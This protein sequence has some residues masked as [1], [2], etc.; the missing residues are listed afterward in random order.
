MRAFRFAPAKTPK[1]VLR[2]LYVDVGRALDAAEVKS[3]LAIR[4]TE[5]IGGSPEEFQRVVRAELRKWAKLAQ[6]VGIKPE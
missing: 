6:G 1:P 3:R 5:P 4:G 2:K